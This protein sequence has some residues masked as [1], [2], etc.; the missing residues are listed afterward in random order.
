[1]RKAAFV[2]A[3][4][5]SSIFLGG[6]VFFSGCSHKKTPPLKLAQIS[7]EILTLSN[8]EFSSKKNDINNPEMVSKINQDIRAKSAEIFK[9]NGLTME[10]YSEELRYLSKKERELYNQEYTRLLIASV[11]I[12]PA[13]AGQAKIQSK[14]V[15]TPT[16][17]A[18]ITHRKTGRKK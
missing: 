16:M 12:Q 10:K 17:H 6:W 3:L 15:P 11:R 18:A 4:V 7:F 5:V 2:R 1:M 13:P 8:Q 14:L 9:R